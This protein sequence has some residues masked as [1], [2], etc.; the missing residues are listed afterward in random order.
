MS[1]TESEHSIP[2]E[3]TLTVRFTAAADLELA[4]KAEATDLIRGVLP[5]SEVL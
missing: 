4:E 1:S 3:G 5:S 2:T